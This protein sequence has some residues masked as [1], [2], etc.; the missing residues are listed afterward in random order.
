MEA[1]MREYG[2]PNAIRTDNGAPFASCGIGGLSR[3]SVWWIRLG[4]RPERIRPGKPQENG[5]HERMHLTLKQNTAQ[6]PA[7]TLRDQQRRFDVFRTE[8][9]QQRPHAA[10]EMKTPASLFQPTTRAYPSR[11]EEPTYPSHYAT[12]RVGPCGTLRWGCEKYFVGK[13]LENQ[14]VGLEPI[15]D[16]NWRVWFSVYPLGTLLEREAKI[17]PEPR[18]KRR[19]AR[20]N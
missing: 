4:I 6:P 7:A 15:D 18:P 9:N 10:L 16:S 11:I 3:L 12:R 14:T 5:R 20:K 17:V 13:V 1:A 8:F 19:G 2:V